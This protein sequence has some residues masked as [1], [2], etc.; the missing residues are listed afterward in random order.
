MEHFSCESTGGASRLRAR[1]PLRLS[2]TG[3]AESG[4]GKYCAAHGLGCDVIPEVLL[5]GRTVS[6]TYIR[7]L[8]TE[9]QMEEAERYLG[10]AHVC[11]AWCG[12]DLAAARKIDMP[13]ANLAFR[14][15]VLVPAFG[16]YAAEAE[17]E[18]GAGRRASTSA[19]IRRRVRWSGRCSRRGSRGL[20]RPLWEGDRG[21][22]L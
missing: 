21:F 3:H 14:R 15:G 10:H 13:T 1:F 6:S 2:R 19:S 7:T 16:V 20:R 12:T 22:P 18:G 11:L 9:G 8:L 5:D 17:T 4:C